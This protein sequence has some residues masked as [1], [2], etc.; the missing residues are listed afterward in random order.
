MPAH[1]PLA[2]ALAYWIVPY[3]AEPLYKFSPAEGAMNIL[4]HNSMF[5]TSPL[6]LND[7]FEMRPA[8]TNAHEQRFQANQRRRDEMMAGSPILVCTHEGLVD[9]GEVLQ[10]SQPETPIDVDHQRGISDGHNGRVFAHMHAKYRVLSLVAG[11]MPATDQVADTR[12][13]KSTL[14]WA[15]YA[16][17]F[18]GVCIAVDPDVFASGIKPGGYSVDYC[19][20][21]RFLPPEEYDSI[22]RLSAHAAAPVGYVID[23]STGLALP[24][25]SQEEINQLRFIQILTNKSPAWEYE[26]EVRMLYD[27]LKL[28]ADGHQRDV[29]LACASCKSAGRQLE[30]CEHQNHRDAVSVPPSAIRAV[31]FGT[32]CQGKATQEILAI[33]SDQRYSHVDVYWSALHSEKHIIQYTKSTPSYIQLIQKQR[34][35]EIA[36]AKGQCRLEQDVWKVKNSPKGINYPDFGRRA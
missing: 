20:T 2:I 30:E 21:R 23:H 13:E 14:M 10:P 6:D 7:P 24:P 22:L 35:N 16:D 9:S 12:Y 4:R 32:D 31:I 26:Q 28:K 19:S 29:W 1:F 25:A 17:M 11:L 5:I 34:S 27:L 36:Y 3:M 18:Q 15:H 33:L 8:W